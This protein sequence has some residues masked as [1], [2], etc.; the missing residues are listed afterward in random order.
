[1]IGHRSSLLD[2]FPPQ[3]VTVR[4]A[5]ERLEGWCHFSGDAN[6]VERARRGACFVRQGDGCWYALRRT[7]NDFQVVGYFA[8][9]AE[10]DPSF[11]ADV[12]AWLDVVH[13]V[14]GPVR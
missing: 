5:I 14:F 8:A 6:R 13:A 11:Q 3:L 12:D 7:G 9:G 4:E 2:P 1:V 10:T